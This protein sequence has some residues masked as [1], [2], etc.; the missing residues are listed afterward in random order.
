[1]SLLFAML[2][3]LYWSTFG[4]SLSKN[5]NKPECTEREVTSVHSSLAVSYDGEPGCQAECQIS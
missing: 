2:T 1:M 3:S 5:Q 4:I